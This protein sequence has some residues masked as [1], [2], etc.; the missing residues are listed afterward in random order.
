MR[1]H[2]PGKLNIDTNFLSRMLCLYSML[3]TPLLYKLDAQWAE[4]SDSSADTPTLSM[5]RYT[6]FEHDMES[7]A[8]NLV[9]AGAPFDSLQTLTDPELLLPSATV[10]VPER[11]VVRVVA[12][13]GPSELFI[14]AASHAKLSKRGLQLSSGTVDEAETRD[15]ALSPRATRR[16]RQHRGHTDR[17]VS[18]HTPRGCSC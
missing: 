10:P 5:L 1:R 8:H 2:I 7:T 12:N 15:K 17:A 4:P 14:N 6:E 13:D 18:A 11:S 16:D 3:P 9:S